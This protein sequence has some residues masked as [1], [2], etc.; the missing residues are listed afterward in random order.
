MDVFS[1]YELSIATILSID[2]T[3]SRALAQSPLIQLGGILKLGALHLDWLEG[4]QRVVEWSAIYMY[5]RFRLF[6]NMII[7]SR[8]TGVRDSSLVAFNVRAK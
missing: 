5:I 6:G 7:S 2:T 4:S 3:C 8:S 1:E